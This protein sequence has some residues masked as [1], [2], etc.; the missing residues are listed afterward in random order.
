MGFFLDI[1]LYASMLRTATPLILGLTG[2]IL[3]DRSGVVNVFIE[4]T[5][6]TGAFC[7]SYWASIYHNVWLGVGMAAL[8]GMFC[9]C[10]MAILTV[11]LKADQ[12]VVGLGLNFIALGI[13][14]MLFSLLMFDSSGQQLTSPPFG[15][16]EIPYLANIPVV[17]T[18]LFKQRPLLYIALLILGIEYCALYYTHPGLILRSV[19]EK[20]SVSYSQGIR[21]D[22]VRSISVIIGSAIMGVGGS[23]FALV[24]V[25]SFKPNLTI[26]R[27]FM[28]LAAMIAGK[29]HPLLGFAAALIFGFA[30]AF[31]WKLQAMKL[32]IPE[33][34]PNM[35]PY[36]VTIIVLAGIIGKATAP[37]DLG[38]PFHREE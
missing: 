32:P 37:G 24:E 5:M 11:R 10:I 18:L 2:C 30:E 21:V 13:T 9:G 14:S 26:G 36:I 19:G 16:W 6:L 17:G 23:Y 31:Q 22:V 27:G 33:M 28:G 7:A 8:A 35:L 34:L 4:G 15:W 25:T 29:W 1:G 38:N 20:A 12:I 3:C